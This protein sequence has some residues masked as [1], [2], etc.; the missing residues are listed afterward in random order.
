MVQG[1]AAA[2]GSY[3]AAEASGAAMLRGV[4]QQVGAAVNARTDRAGGS[5]AA[6]AASTSPDA[7]KAQL[8]AVAPEVPTSQ[9][10]MAQFPT[11]ISS[12]AATTSAAASGAAGDGSAGVAVSAASTSAGGAAATT[13]T[14]AATA[15]TTT[16]AG[17]ATLAAGTADTSLTATYA[18]SS[19][20]G[21]GFIANYTITTTRHP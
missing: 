21:N 6:T 5:G 17:A 13:A 16:A 9:A 1:L 12:G 8:S 11:G 18:T 20:R 15:A 10:A 19:Q 7:A 3:T 2:V 4:G 14:S